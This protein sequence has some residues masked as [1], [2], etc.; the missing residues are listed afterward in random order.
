MKKQKPVDI[1]E[2]IA[3]LPHTSNPTTGE[4]Y[5]TAD[6]VTAENGYPFYVKAAEAI[7]PEN[8]LEIGSFLGFGLVAFLA[9]Y[10]DVDRVTSMDNETYLAD[11]RNLCR[12]NVEAVGRNV[13][14]FRD[15][16]ELN[17]A[18][19][20]FDLI[21]VDAHHTVED[22]IHDMAYCWALRPRVML[23]DD[24]LFLGDVAKAVHWFAA[25]H[26]IPFKV[27]ES[28]R[29]WAVFAEPATFETLPETL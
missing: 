25:H 7:Q 17:A 14:T 12:E 16:T 22:A 23:V 10:P 11:S 13:G 26:G 28:Y 21:H 29:G 20:D 1:R 15:Y 3:T 6:W 2:V 19:G 9:G 5:R 18:T 24:Y 8:I 4:D 27:W